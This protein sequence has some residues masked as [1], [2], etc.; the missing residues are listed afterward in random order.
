MADAEM[1]FPTSRP[2]CGTPAG[3]YLTVREKD[4][5]DKLQEHHTRPRPQRSYA[6]NY[7]AADIEVVF[8]G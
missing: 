3:R 4:M 7:A 8:G 2:S 6:A 5:F 1:P